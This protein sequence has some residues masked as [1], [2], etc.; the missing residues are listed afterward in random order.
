MYQM[1]PLYINNHSNYIKLIIIT[2]NYILN[3]VKQ[4]YLVINKHFLCV[5][6]LFMII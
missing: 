2:I 5:N 3:K 4:T 1:I 6:V